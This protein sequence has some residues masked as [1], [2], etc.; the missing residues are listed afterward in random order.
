MSAKR[1]RL[2]YGKQY[3]RKL[4][5]KRVS[6]LLAAYN[7][8]GSNNGHHEGSQSTLVNIKD[9]SLNTPHMSDVQILEENNDQKSFNENREEESTY[10][11][12][13]KEISNDISFRS[14]LALWA[15]QENISH[16]ALKKLL[17]ILKEG[18]NPSDLSDLPLDPRT[19]LNTPSKT[20]VVQSMDKGLYHYFGI[21]R[22]INIIYHQLS[23]QSV[24][25]QKFNMMVNID[26]V[27]LFKSTNESF[28]PILC[29]IKVF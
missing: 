22:T 24:E 2:G 19:L 14:K 5:F 23:V 9:T 12:T 17:F 13:Y 20:P 18:V 21:Q 8:S 16:V 26:G 7:R 29:E 27:P 3:L 6:G 1:T 15:V 11:S 25:H 10:I 4:R 28:W